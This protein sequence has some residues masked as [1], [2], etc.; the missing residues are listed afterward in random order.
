M[1]QSKK[2]KSITKRSRDTYYKVYIKAH[3]NAVQLLDEAKLLFSHGHCARAYALAFTGLEEI[4]KSQLAADV[5]TRHIEPEDFESVYTLHKV[6]ISRV[7]W[8]HL[9]AS[10]YPYN[11]A[12]IGPDMD[13]VMEIEAVEPS[14]NQRNNA[15]F[16]GLDGD[17]LLI[18]QESVSKDMARGV[19][20]VLEVAIQ[21]I[22]EVTEYHGHQIGTKGFMK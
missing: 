13:D 3:N 6:K 11:T 5:Y 4:S 10:E 22:V 19:I 16:V 8:A 1:S 9:D 15:L 7:E 18:P 12:W 21:R 14:W 20:H 2:P 17:R